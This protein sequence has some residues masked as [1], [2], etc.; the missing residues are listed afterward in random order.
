MDAMDR[1]ELVELARQQAAKI[2]SLEAEL[3]RLKCALQTARPGG[4]QPPISG[5]PA[6]ERPFGIADALIVIAAI[7]LGLTVT[8][9]LVP[10]LT[11]QMLWD[12]FAAIP[13]AELTFW[14][15]M[16]GAAE[17][18]SLLVI[19]T[20]TFTTLACL[21]MRLRAPRPAQHRFVRQ[22][23][24]MACLAVTCTIALATGPVVAIRMYAASEN[25]G[26]QDFI[27]AV[28][29]VAAFLGVGIVSCWT[30]MAL[31]GRWRPERTW[32]DRLGRLIGLGWVVSAGFY[33]G[34]L[35]IAFWPF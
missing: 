33:G 1:D 2:E 31:S 7:A 27:V 20:Y 10:G 17:A 6:T 14:G 25:P 34:L 5:E 32:I 8:R 16:A 21:A 28:Y 18:G 35:L 4:K 23:G 22:P 19:P 26:S 13:Q 30:A 29:M 9:S 12:A 15:V 3:D 24:A 11:P